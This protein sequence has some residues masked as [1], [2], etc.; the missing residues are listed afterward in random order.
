MS[1]D[2]K[3]WTNS[4]VKIYMPFCQF[5]QR[6]IYT[7][8]TESLQKQLEVF[9]ISE[10]KLSEAYLRIRELVG[11]WETPTAPTPEQIYSLTESKIIAL[12]E[13]NEMLRREIARLS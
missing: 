6:E 7:C 9:K 2:P 4:D 11:A 13:E 10:K 8:Q 12:K 3:C 5:H 1:E